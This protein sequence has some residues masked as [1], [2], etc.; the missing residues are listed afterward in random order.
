MV[1]WCDTGTVFR[2]TSYLLSSKYCKQVSALV[3]RCL[4]LPHDRACAD[5]VCLDIHLQLSFQGAVR[6]TAYRL[7]DFDWA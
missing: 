2:A 3:S 5:L 7:A 1:A 6:C 4:L